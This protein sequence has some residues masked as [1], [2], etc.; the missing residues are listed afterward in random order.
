M[1]TA[2]LKL[3]VAIATGAVLLSC[4]G[5]TSHPALVKPTRTSGDPTAADPCATPNT[6]CPCSNV[7]ETAACGRV[8]IRSGDYVTCSNGTRECLIDGTWGECVGDLVTT[9]YVGQGTVPSIGSLAYIHTQAVVGPAQCEDNPCDPYCNYTGDDGQNLTNLPSGLCTGPTGGVV[10][11]D[12]KCVYSGPHAKS[13]YQSLG[14]GWQ[15]L[16]ASC[17]SATDAC[18]YDTNCGATATCTTWEPPCYDPNPPGCAIAKRIDLELGPPCAAAG[19]TYHFQ[20]CNRGADRADA[21][22]IK[23]G[24]YSDSAKLSTVVASGS[25]PG[26]PDKG[27]VSFTLGTSPGTFIDP[28]KCLDINPGNSTPNPNP[29]VGLTATRAIAVNYDAS[30]AECNYANNWNVFDASIGCTGCT[31][32]E[33]NQTCAA[34]NL[35]GT[36]YDPAGTNPIPGVIVYVPNGTVEPLEDGVHCD[37]C[38]NL[39]TGTPI[40]STMTGTDGKFTLANIPSGVNFPL[41]VQIGRWRRQVSVNAIAACASGVLPAGENSRLPSKQS[42]GSI[43]KMALSMSAGDHLECLLR[44]IGIE[45]SEFTV[46]TGTGRVHLYAFNGMTFSRISCGTCASG[47]KCPDGSN[48][49]GSRTCATT[50]GTCANDLWSSPTTLD[51]YNAVIAPCD[52]S[53]TG[54]PAS[55]P[56]NSYVG[57]SSSPFGYAV[58]PYPNAWGFHSFNEAQLGTNPLNHDKPPFLAAPDA[59]NSALPPSPTP[60]QATNL[61]NYIDK[62]GRLFSTHWMANFL[63]RDTYPGAVNYTYGAYVDFDRQ[64]TGTTGTDF[65]YTIDTTSATGQTFA[66]WLGDT[67]VTFT[68]WRHLVESVNT[69]TVRLAY[70]DSRAA[71]VNHPTCTAG[72]APT[73]SVSPSSCSNMGQGWGGPMVSAYQF[74]T[75]WGATATN[76]CGRVVVAE[77]HVSK[78]TGS[79]QQSAF[80]GTCDSSAMNGEE[81]AFE[82]LMFSTTQCVGLVTPPTPITP[83][84]PAS[85]MFDYQ[86][87]CPDGTQV[88]W[89]F[90]S[91]QAIVPASTSIVFTAQTADTQEG[92]AA[93]PPVTVG[94]ASADTTKWTSDA[95]TVNWHL[96]NDLGTPVLSARW[97]RVSATLNPTGNTTPTLTQWQQIFDCIP[98]Q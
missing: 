3:L 72:A 82:Y 10:L 62:G 42:E 68:N 48:C 41:V 90:F 22:V 32:L 88:E 71:P 54:A 58:G 66:S 49:P 61:K 25:S 18:G 96:M 7:G 5:E 59:G 29:L 50:K 39:Y 31:N 30:L 79:N 91:W 34:T 16:P 65:P 87:V 46:P 84:Q 24:V 23:I 78:V 69:P 33:C 67:E 11:C 37:T 38:E 53:P 80:P 28:G 98:A 57:T 12:Q 52:K 93:A 6:G 36:I 21:G 73:Y 89:E 13:G 17:T 45:D 43:P 94:T 77:S 20:V 35:T 85:Y 19:S 81:K 63:T 27:S 44:K 2:S 15:K 26:A 95:N 47:D 64:G 74:D 55:V 9:T 97:L 75:P 4:S 8:E 51:K 60:T 1:E 86:G 14:T 83:L 40:A 76:Q 92:L 70:G 56:A